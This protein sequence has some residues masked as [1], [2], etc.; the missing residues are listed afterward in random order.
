[1]NI[2]EIRHFKRIQQ[3]LCRHQWPP[4][5]FKLD[6]YEKVY[7]CPKCGKSKKVHIND[8]PEY[9]NVLPTDYYGN[10][11]RNRNAERTQMR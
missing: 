4:V 6:D 3:L 7:T 5:N 10:T 2:F 8:K 9:I 1:M 11:F